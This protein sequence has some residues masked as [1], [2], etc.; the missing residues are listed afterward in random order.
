MA[1]TE[2]HRELIPPQAIEI[3]QAVLGSMMTDSNA[4]NRALE[5]LKE[6]SFYRTAHKKIFSAI[7]ALYEKSDAVDMITVG[8]ELKKRNDLE[9]IGGEYYLSECI[10]SVTATANIAYH[11]KLVYEKHILRELI[12]ISNMISEEA[13]EANDDAMNILDR[14]EQKI[15]DISESRLQRGFQILKPI[16]K[17]TFDILETYSARQGETIGIPTGFTKLD[18]M[19]GGFQNGDL[20][21]IA[22]RPSMGKTALALNAARNAAVE[23]NAGVGFFSLEMA[24]YQ[25]TMRLLCSEARLDAHRV[26]TGRLKPEEWQKLSL[27]VGK[28]SDAPMFIDDNA[29]LNLIEMRAKARRLKKEHD[30]GIIYIDYLQLMQ[31]HER[32]NSRQEEISI[33]SRGLKAMAKELNVPV[34]VLSQLSRAVEQRGGDKRPMLSDLRE[35]GAIEQDADVVLFIYRPEYYG[36]PNDE[37]GNS[38][39]GVGQVII[40]KQRN[41]PVGT[42]DLTFIKE[43]TRFE[44]LAI[45]Y[46][47]KDIPF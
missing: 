20:I 15:Y 37:E 11:S 39:E 9:D 4:I 13:Y 35:S 1:K 42:V 5:V 25:L 33:I 40:G 26:R 14:A 29:G 18:E 34:V 30:I 3:E 31:G 32:T 36:I 24:S 22:G 6:H 21:I 12:K 19:T 27:N 16:L 7:L 10:S 8:E 17:E 38:Y 43:Y 41:G 28:L 44:N 46:E 23:K 45:G 2:K 47:E